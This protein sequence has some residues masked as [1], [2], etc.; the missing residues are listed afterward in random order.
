MDVFDQLIVQPNHNTTLAHQLRQQLT[1]MIANGQLKAGDRL[2]TV[3]QMAERLGIN[4]HT[5][6]KAYQNLQAVGLIETR[7]GRGTHVLPFDLH[8][9]AQATRAQR[10]HTVGVIV[11]SWSNPFYHAFLQGVEEIAGEDQTLIFL[12]NTHDDPDAAWRDFARLSAKQVDGILIASHDIAEALT[13]VQADSPQ[14]HELPYVTVDWPGCAGYSVQIDL[15]SAGYLATRHLLDHERH[16][17]DLITFALN[18]ANIQPVNAGYERALRERGLPV[19]P[20]RIIR[21]PAF[22]PAAGAEGARRLLGLK[23]PPDAIFAIS[24]T[25]ALGAMQA[26]KAAGFRIPG[27]IALVGFNDIP[28]AALVEPQLT[29]VAAPT[30]QLGREAMKMLQ[31]LIEGRRPPR[32]SITLPTS[33]VIRQSCG[34]HPQH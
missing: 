23:T 33:L 11:P 5:V 25:L 17:P 1:W 15:E 27:D 13:P 21:V 26:I 12:C 29:T 24:D 31:T 28:I 14:P 9:F 20:D 32:R 34:E 22:D 19:D 3:H 2:P 30:V 16:R 10:T 4:L 18:S 8:R 7:R 6:R